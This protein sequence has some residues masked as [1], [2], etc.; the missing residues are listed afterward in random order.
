MK[1]LVV[2]LTMVLASGFALAGFSAERVAVEDTTPPAASGPLELNRVGIPAATMPKP[3]AKPV[4]PM[5]PAPT[6]GSA[7]SPSDTNPDQAV[8]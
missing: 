4:A 3:E 1:K 6:T 2:S 8:E 5:N 7:T